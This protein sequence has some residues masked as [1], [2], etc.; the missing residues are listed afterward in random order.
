MDIQYGLN[1]N[2]H[3]KM[4]TSRREQFQSLLIKSSGIE[5]GVA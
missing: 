2:Q 3:R 1:A 4:L 5:S